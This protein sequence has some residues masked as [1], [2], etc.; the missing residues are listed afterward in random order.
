MAEE[1]KSEKK[2]ALIIKGIDKDLKESLKGLAETSGKAVSEL[3]REALKLYVTMREVGA[4]AG[5]AIVS[6]TQE[7]LSQPNVISIKN[8]GE[9]SLSK[10]DLL[11][12]KEKIALF[13]ID[14]LEFADDVTLD[15]FQEKIERIVNVKELI[16]PKSIP[17]SV[18]LPK[19]SYINKIIQK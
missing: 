14:K 17:K 18:I 16:I 5:K 12:F 8:I 1:E 15:V 6:T 10:D 7:L 4:Q 2:E 19:C 13:N 3:A 11:S 9:L